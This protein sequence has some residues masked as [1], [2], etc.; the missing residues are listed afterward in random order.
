MALIVL[1][2]ASVC[3]ACGAATTSPAAPLPAA[4]TGQPQRLYGADRYATAAAVA[5]AGH[6]GGVQTAVVARGDTFPDALASGPLAAQL[7]AALLLTAPDALPGSTGAALQQ[8][9]VSSVVIVGGT[10]AVSSAVQDQLQTQ[11]SVSRIAGADRYATAAAVARA[12]VSA[13]PIRTSNGT[14]AAFFV[15]GQDFP[16]AMVAGAVAAEGTPAPILLVGRDAVTSATATAIGGLHIGAGWVV[17]AQGAVSATTQLSLVSSG[18]HAITRLGGVNRQATAVAVAREFHPTASRMVIAR[19]DDFADALTAGPYAAAMGAPVLLTADPT[20]LGTDTLDAV[21]ST[22][23][24]A[25]TSRT[26]T[27]VGGPAAVSSTVAARVGAA[28]T[29]AAPSG[30][31][32][33]NT[34]TALSADQ[35]LG[36]LFALAVPA[37]SGADATTRSAIA[38]LHVGNVFLAGRSNAGVTATHNL[39]GGLRALFTASATGGVAPYIATDQEGGQVQVLSGPGF[40]AIPTALAQGSLSAATLNADATTW[41]RQLAAAGVNSNFAP[42]AGTVPPTN[43]TANQ[44]IGRYYREYGYTPGV[45]APHVVAFAQGMAAGGIAATVK[46][47]PGLGR[48]SG[49]TDTTA[50]VTDSVTTIADPYL[51][52]FTDAIRAGAPMV[53]MSSAIYTRIDASTLAAFS[54]VVVRGLLRGILGFGGLVVSDSLNAA[55]LNSTPIGERGSDFIAAGGDLALVTATSSASAMIN[56][57]YNRAA[58]DGIFRTIADAAAL[59]VLRAKAAA[60]LLPCS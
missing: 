30:D 6:P 43:P 8:L 41:A 12:V 48:A 29:G 28:A 14:P 60:G 54:P 3:V 20:T 37:T 25:G 59:H 52:P 23:V 40:S 10:S 11:Y 46:H 47:F 53:M 56:G 1:P 22:E 42:V 18:V 51:Q 32:A 38:N 17:G 50:G 33:A 31:C 27:I 16:D 35:R 15:T 5:V 57:L 36:Q 2:A 34:F 45:V 58:G 44:P 55:A 13:G 7:H 49:N 39:T 4:S 24:A 9:G 19:G 21:L 26:L